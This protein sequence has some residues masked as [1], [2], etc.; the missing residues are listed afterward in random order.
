MALYI[1]WPL[2]MLKFEWE[3]AEGG[4]ICSDGSG[5]ISALLL[6]DVL[7]SHTLLGQVVLTL[8]EASQA[9]LV[10]ATVR[11]QPSTSS[12]D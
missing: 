5:D 6:D 11:V 4:G 8:T 10:V 7:L 2:D 1:C 3:S 12:L 9:L